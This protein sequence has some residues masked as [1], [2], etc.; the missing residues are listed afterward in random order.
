MAIYHTTER[1]KDNGINQVTVRGRQTQHSGY[2]WDIYRNG[3][4]SFPAASARM[5][6]SQLGIKV[7]VPEVA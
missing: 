4:V 2:V 5:V 1:N 6:Y 7:E 3:K